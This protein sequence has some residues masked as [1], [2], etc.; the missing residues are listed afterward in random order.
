MH[1]CM[2]VCMYVVGMHVMLCIHVCMYPCMYPCMCVCG[3]KCMRMHVR[4]IHV[5]TCIHTRPC[6]LHI[7]LN[8][9]HTYTSMHPAYF[10]EFRYA[11]HTCFVFCTH[12]SVLHIYIRNKHTY[13]C[14]CTLVHT[15]HVY[16]HIWHMH[17]WYTCILLIYVNSHTVNMLA[18]LGN[19]VHAYR[20]TGTQPPQAFMYLSVPDTCMY[21]LHLLCVCMPDTCMYAWYMYIHYTRTDT[22]QRT[23]TYQ[24]SHPQTKIDIQHEYMYIHLDGYWCPQFREQVQ[25]SRALV[26]VT[27][28]QSLRLF[29]RYISPRKRF[30]LTWRRPW[31]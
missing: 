2:Y 9:M 23:Y 1:A 24:L 14:M 30:P 6:I 28:C 8:T 15:I 10:S 17:L 31:F 7:C 25:V 21:A 11:S 26:L 3:S 12:A 19:D 29:V 4:H 18:Y 27:C 13:L 22:P 5:H 16:T 20:H